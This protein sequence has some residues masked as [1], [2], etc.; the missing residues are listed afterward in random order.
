MGYVLGKDFGNLGAE[1]TLL[2]PCGIYLQ[3]IPLL[4]GVIY[5][6]IRTPQTG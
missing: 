5:K 2:L 4:N 6:D 3:Q 1:H